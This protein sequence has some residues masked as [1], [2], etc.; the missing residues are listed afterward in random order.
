MTNTFID[1]ASNIP[2]SVVTAI[3]RI[4]ELKGSWKASGT[5]HPHILKNLKKSVLVTSTGASTRIEGS[6][7]SDEDIEKLM[8]GIAIE[9]FTDR[10]SQEVRGYYELLE[11]V[12]NTYEDFRLSESTIKH[13]HKELLKYGEKDVL[14]R[15]DYKK[16]ENKVH[17]VNDAGESIGIFFDTSPVYLTP[18]E[19]KTL[20]EWTNKTLH[21]KVIHPLIVIG[22]FIVE[23]L[24]IHPFADG[25]GRLSR[26]LTNALLLK[27]GYTYV[28]YVSHEKLIEDN[29]PDYY[30]ALRNSQKTFKTDHPDISPWLA[31][32][33]SVLLI[34]AESAVKLLTDK[35]TE[36]ILSQKQLAVWEYLGSHD[37]GAPR[38]I[39]AA[40]NVSR[41]TV[42]QA[43][44]KLVKL[45]KVQR[46]GL[47]RSTRYRKE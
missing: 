8:R 46:L 7:L 37:E 39:A 27:S 40:T 47:G 25:N 26:I 36:G 34:Q 1:L 31:F 21:E 45:G 38:E 18:L 10:D 28:P 11:N 42:K 17:M 4:D 32:F 41:A 24:S 29:K 22:I 30:L 12:F 13:F 44:D 14:H 15:G 6:K 19:M 16:T 9:K 43:L 5:L 33:T 2:N 35:T 20:V 23:F 3:A